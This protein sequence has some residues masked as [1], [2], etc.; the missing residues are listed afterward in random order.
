MNKILLVC[1]LCLT[2]SH[3]Q[4][5]QTSS[6]IIDFNKKNLVHNTQWSIC[7]IN[8]NSKKMICGYNDHVP[9][10]PASIQ[11]LIITGIALKYIDS[12]FR[13][14][15]TL[16]YDGKILHDTLYGNLYIHGSGDPTFGSDVFATTTISVVFK[17]FTDAITAAGIHTIKGSVIGDASVFDS[18]LFPEKEWKKEDYGNYYGAGA[19]GLNF[20]ENYYTINFSS[21]KYVNEEVSVKSVR[22]AVPAMQMENKVSSAKA[23]TGDNVIIYGE[24]YQ[25]SRALTGTIPVNADS[26]PVKGS[27]PDPAYACAWHFDRYLK[28]MGITISGAP[29][30]TFIASEKRKTIAVHYSPVF[31]DIV[32]ETNIHSNNVYAESILKTLALK[33]SGTGSTANGISELCRQ[34]HT[35]ENFHIVDGS[36]L[37]VNNTLTAEAM[38]GF[39]EWMQH[40][41]QYSSFYNSLPVAGREGSLKNMLLNTPL[42]DNLHA[43]SG[44]MKGVR[45]YAGYLRNNKNEPIAFCIMVNGFTC[46]PSEMQKEIE[47]LILSLY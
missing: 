17:N 25:N 41:P 28:D 12:S 43:K 21:G 36:G 23:G 47:K 40:Q 30:R 15:T 33:R 38:V 14:Q 46:Y 13:Y 8:T 5:Q 39:L 37:S 1:I 3:L 4:S 10:Q 22:P 29:A 6:A 2:V 35:C 44:S 45:C 19:C 16:E 20:H 26:F 32:R 34:L 27:I 42:T 18:L 31:S 24:P 9:L 7:A 11:K